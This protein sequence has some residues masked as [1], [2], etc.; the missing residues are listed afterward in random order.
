MRIG[1][2]EARSRLTS[3]EVVAL[4][5]DTVC[6]L[7]SLAN[8]SKALQNLLSLKGRSRKKP[9]TI[10]LSATPELGK[11]L[12]KSIYLPRCFP[13]CLEAWWPGPCTVVLPVIEDLPEKL[14]FSDNF[15]GFRVP[16]HPELQSFLRETGPLAVTSANFSGEIPAVY[17]E[18]V[19]DLF[20]QDFPCLELDASRT[21]GLESTVVK[22]LS[23]KL[24][25]LREGLVSVQELA[26]TW[27][28]KI[29]WN[30]KNPIM[31]K[32]DKLFS[33]GFP[34]YPSKDNLILGFSNRKYEAEHKIF[35]GDDSNLQEVLLHFYPVLRRAFDSSCRRIYLDDAWPEGDLLWKTLHRRLNSLT[36]SESI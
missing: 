13:R 33:W 35:W 8:N 3:G 17:L 2:Q 28:K 20:G 27:D 1:T 24:E 22:V 10:M 7:A 29:Q 15:C 36:N 5:T 21:I 18:E 23:D 12:L 14:C 30:Q 31:E 16:R 19:E 34:T 6:G 32:H 26:L 9:I 4:P 11:L 25:V